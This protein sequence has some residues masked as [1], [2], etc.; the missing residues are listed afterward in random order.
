MATKE[1]TAMMNEI[2]DLKAQIA[3]LQKLIAAERPAA[4]PAKLMQDREAEYQ[5]KVK[6]LSRSCLDRTQEFAVKRW[7]GDSGVG[8]YRVWIKPENGHAEPGTLVLI[9]P[10]RSEH[11]ALGRYRE[12]NG[13]RSLDVDLKETFELLKPAEAA[14]ALKN[15]ASYQN[16]SA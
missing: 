4:L 2:A 14:E 10:A 13:I 3:N 16:I 11:E 9:I 5:E 8:W 6:E 7:G 1:E 15:P 12:L